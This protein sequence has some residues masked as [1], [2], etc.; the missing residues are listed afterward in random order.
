MLRMLRYEE[1]LYDFLVC[2]KDARGSLSSN[3]SNSSNSSFII[4][5]TEAQSICNALEMDNTSGLNYLSKEEV[6]NL[7]CISADKKKM[8]WKLVKAVK[9]DRRYAPDLRISYE[10]IANIRISQIS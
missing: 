7:S 2:Q 8:L 3:S 4:T 5:E 9:K 10:D 1:R 6:I